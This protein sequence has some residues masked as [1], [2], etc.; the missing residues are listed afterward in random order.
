M[1]RATESGRGGSGWGGGASEFKN[2]IERYELTCWNNFYRSCSFTS[3][4]CYNSDMFIFFR[5][6][7]TVV[8]LLYSYV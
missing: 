4:P 7:A 5:I 3:D 6:G 8:F 1:H 2:I